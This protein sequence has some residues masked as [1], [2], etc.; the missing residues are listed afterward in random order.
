MKNS[1]LLKKIFFVSFLF[2]PLVI[3]SLLPKGAQAQ[4]VL[5]NSKLR[6]GNGGEN[7][8]NTF[9]NLQQPFYYNSNRA[10]WFA[11]TYSNNPLDNAFAIGGVKTDEWNVNGT[12][13]VN[14]SLENQVINASQYVISA[15]PNGYGTIV[16]TGNVTI[17]SQMLEVRNTYLLPQNSAY[18][19]VTT[20]L[21]NV[22]SSPME[23]VRTWIGTRDDWIGQTD[24]PNK[25]K[26]NLVNGAFVRN[27]ATTARAKAL[28]IST[29]EEG[30]MFYTD[31][32]KGNIIVNPR[33]GDFRTQIVSMNPTTSSL[34][35]TSDGSYGFYV[36]MND[37]P[38][39]ASDEFTWYYAA[40]EL[41]DLNEIINE[42]AQVSGSVSNITTNSADLAASSS[43]AATGY[44]MVVPHGAARPTAAQIKAGA[45]YGQVVVTSKGSG[46]MLANAE[47]IFKMTSLSAATAYDYYFVTED[48]TAHFSDIS[49]GTFTT[50]ALPSISQVSDLAT[51]QDVTTPAIT[52]TVG[53]A[54]TAPAALTITATSSNTDLIT[55]ENITFGGTGASRTVSL[56]QTAGQVGT[57]TITLTVTDAD[58]DQATTT[59]TVTVNLNDTEPPVV[60]NV[61]YYQ[62]EEASSLSEQV[63]GSNLLWYEAATGGTGSSTVPTPTTSSL[64]S[65]E[66]WVSQTVGGCP[67]ERVKITVTIQPNN[68]ITGTESSKRAYFKQASIVDE[69]LT[70]SGKDVTEARVYIS[71]GF[72]ANADVLSI[73]TLPEGI[74]SSFNANTGVLTFTGTASAA[75]MQEILR[76]VTFR[77]TSSNPSDRVIK[78]AVVNGERTA[79]S[80]RTLT[81]YKPAT[82]SIPVLT[83]G[84]NGFINDATPTVT[85]TAEPNVQVTIYNGTDSIA[86]VTAGEDG[87]WTYTFTSDQSEGEHNLSASATDLLGFTGDKSAALPIVVD[88]Q[89]PVTPEVPV[90]TGGNQGNTKDNTPTITGTVE[91]NATVTIYTNGTITATVTAN[92]EGNWT[93]TYSDALSDA[94]Y[95]ITVTATDAA[96][97]ISETSPA[98]EIMID[99]S[100]PTTP[101]TPVLTGGNNGNTNDNTPTISGRAE[102]GSQVTIYRN[103]EAVAT[104]TA[105]ETG[106]WTYTFTTALEDGAQEITVVATD[107]AGNS[108]AESEILTIRVDTTEPTTPTI[109]VLAGGNNGN[110]NDNTPTINGK[111]EAG[112]QVTIYRNGEAVATVTADETGAWTYTFTTALEDG[113]QEI[114]VVAT[115]AAGNSSAKSETLTIRVDTQKPQTP[116]P[117]VLAGGNNGNTNDNTP[118]ISGTVEPNSIVT[119]FTNGTGGETI[120]A[121]ADGNWSYTFESGLTDGEYSFT[122]TAT[123]SAANTS[124]AS[125]ALKITVDTQAP[126][127]PGVPVLAGGNNGNTNDNTPAISGNTEAG[128]EVTIYLNGES[129]ATVT[130]GADGAWGY[131]FPNALP[132]GAYTIA[133]DAKDIAGNVSEQSEILA[134]QVDTVLPTG[135]A[136]TFNA[137]RVDVT[138]VDAITLP[139]SGAEV[140]TTLYYTITCN[141]GGTPV[142]G[143]VK[144]ENAEFDLS[145][146]DLK[147]LNDGTLT[148]VAYLQDAAGNKGAEVTAQTVKIMRNIVDVRTP[149]LI[150][151]PIRTE[152]TRIPL[153]AKVEVTYSTGAKEE[154]SV[155]WNQGNYN[156]AV[157]GQY[158]LTGELVLSPLS[159]N[160]DNKSVQIV[161]EVL[162]NKAPTVLAFDAPTFR[163][164]ASANEVIGTF[165][166]TD[167]DDTEFVYSLVSGQGDVH[168]NLFQ[169][170]GNQ[171]FLKSNNGLSGLTQFTI[172]VRSTDPYNNTIERA[173]TLTKTQY[174]TAVEELKIVNT[175]SPDGDGINDN[176]IVPELKFYNKISIDVFDRSGVHLFHTT[177][178]EKG[179]DGKDLRG[180]VLKGAFF[181][182]IKVEDIQLTKKGVVT[183]L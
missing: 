28:R 17:G 112:S 161:V 139:V 73:G 98:L 101:G 25:Q 113:A 23:N 110:T 60:T 136:V 91:A 179:W 174:A 128:A 123:D 24:G 13:V 62:D 20:R 6:M 50:H 1:T 170:I 52:Y 162:T 150:S 171:L 5:N 82:P 117:P 54:D 32:D 153:P 125:A 121:D 37:L 147:G 87:R 55:N 3:L 169:I 118:T 40:G 75:Q 180:Q 130:A 131:T 42:V 114:T 33:Y 22:S 34:E 120:T 176:W 172:R 152:Y 80:T 4:T 70:I 156:G 11:L 182:V 167:P 134:I 119:I 43:I 104:V 2:L 38:V 155:N 126:A 27:T 7:S 26:G 63:R 30:V 72:Q 105:D 97:N 157:A 71:S 31:S 56:I 57:A 102:A 158:T 12:I 51:C 109:P 129:V 99:T 154:I 35:I 141:N 132:D 146:L 160:L 10:Q 84:T 9:G 93:Y 137:E 86:S 111:A 90:L 143:S 19:K 108:S 64:G 76:S 92:E 66:Y 41:E 78:F 164:E 178:P 89:K 116:V 45:N 175:F 61:T 168:N 16:S 144:V 138:N 53:D 69:Q 159:T 18:I 140:G 68:V 21:R 122:V 67:S 115:D 149:S 81:Y 47:T 106:A 163:P 46:A 135:Y 36:R 181:Y 173:F 88:T 127:V 100:A 124:N 14:P 165:S 59:F 95:D 151:V 39:G 94:D 85:G 177:D 183:I 133:V 74:T 29:S 77:S 79:E 148:V 166:T 142:T 96:G 58:G 15:A 83:G 49:S 65:Q 8:V 48:A 44:W 107:A 145:S 103:G